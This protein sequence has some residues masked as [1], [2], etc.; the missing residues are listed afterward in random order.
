[1]SCFITEADGVFCAV[2][3]LS[4]NKAACCSSLNVITETRIE[5]QG[6]NIHFKYNKISKSHKSQ[7]NQY[8]PDSREASQ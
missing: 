2:Q 8:E 1:M 4:L 6:R 5:I 3:T 7:I